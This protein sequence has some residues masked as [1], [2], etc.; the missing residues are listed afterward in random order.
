MGEQPAPDSA[1]KVYSRDGRFVDIDVDRKELRSAGILHSGGTR[2]Y[3][4]S[5]MPRFLV[6]TRGDEGT[7]VD[8]LRDTIQTALVNMGINPGIYPPTYASR[9]LVL[10]FN[11]GATEEEVT[12]SIVS[13]IKEAVLAGVNPSRPARAAPPRQWETN[14]ES[15][16]HD[17]I[18]TESAGGTR[19][20]NRFVRS[21]RGAMKAVKIVAVFVI[22]LLA[23]SFIFYPAF[24]SRYLPSSVSR[25]IIQAR[26]QIQSML[27]GA[28]NWV[29][30][31]ANGPTVNNAWGEQFMVVIN[32][33]RNR[34]G[35]GT[36]VESSYLDG[37]AQQ[38]FE[39]MEQQPDITHY[40][41]QNIPPGIGEVVY[42]PAGYTPA[43]YASY[44]EKDA[45]LHW[46]NMMD[47]EYTGYG[48]YIASGPVYSINSGC[49]D[50][51]LPGPGIN[52][53]QFFQNEGCTAT[54]G[55]GT[56]LVIDF[57]I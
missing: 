56:W 31:Q 52:V 11:S 37:F 22:L 8:K 45:P 1:L 25:P 53:T 36:L 9:T 54:L 17:S 55:T 47:S 3:K 15:V 32:Q 7:S 50:T 21:R 6:T 42:Y 33:D 38:R 43:N 30:T 20:K 41:Y 23:G 28:A 51:E 27:T 29:S 12:A 48:F 26:D 24:Y 39:T 57:S 49:P 46:E 5:T 44:L 19:R 16:P 18:R 40:G 34:Q 2:D 4:D 13:A 35:L 10:E 14:D